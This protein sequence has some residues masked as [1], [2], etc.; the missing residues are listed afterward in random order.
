MQPVCLA[1]KHLP[2]AFCRRG[3]C[4]LAWA[5]TASHLC[6]LN[7]LL[8]ASLLVQLPASEVPSNSSCAGSECSSVSTGYTLHG[9]SA[10]AAKQILN[11]TKHL[12]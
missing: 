5:K 7:L 1:A 4:G 10:V 12:I 11:E 2:Q 8:L 9:T 6:T 3:P